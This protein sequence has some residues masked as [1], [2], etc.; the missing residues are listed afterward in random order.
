M[1]HRVFMNPTNSS[2]PMNSI[3]SSNPMNPINGNTAALGG[4]DA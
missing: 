3:D 1:A 2:N 4:Y